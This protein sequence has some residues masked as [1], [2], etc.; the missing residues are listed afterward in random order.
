MSPRREEAARLRAQGMTFAQIGKVMGISRVRAFNLLRPPKPSSRRIMPDD[1]VIIALYAG[2]RTDA[3]VAREV[4]VSVSYVRRVRRRHAVQG[5]SGKP[6]RFTPGD[7]E[8]L[9]VMAKSGAT[10]ATIS[11]ELDISPGYACEICAKHGIRR[12]ARKATP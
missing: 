8:R 7:V 12:R 1:A 2:G 11:E 9:L 4:G 5:R 10:Y 3:D 6:S